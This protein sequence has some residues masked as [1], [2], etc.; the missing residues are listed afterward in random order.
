MENTKKTA[1]T[2]LMDE[3]VEKGYGFATLK[4]ALTDITIRTSMV[5]V[6]SDQLIF[7]LPIG[8]VNEDGKLPVAMTSAN[9]TR[10]VSLDKKF[11]ID[12]GL[13]EGEWEEAAKRG[14]L[15]R[16]INSRSPILY[17]MSA[18][19]PSDF[20]QQYDLL[21]PVLKTRKSALQRNQYIM[22]LASEMPKKLSLVL[23]K[24]SGNVNKALTLRSQRYA[25]I[26][27]TVILDIIKSVEK[28]IGNSEVHNWSMTHALTQVDIEFPAMSQEISDTYAVDGYQAYVRVT[29]SDSGEASLRAC[30]MLKKNGHILYC[31]D[32]VSRKHS[33]IPD[34]IR[35]TKDVHEQIFD[36]FI[37]LPEYLC[38]MAMMDV[39]EPEIFVRDAFVDTEK[40]VGKGL[41]RR[42]ADVVVEELPLGETNMLT[43]F[44][45]MMAMPE[46]VETVESSK[47]KLRTWLSKLP[48]KLVAPEET[49]TIL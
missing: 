38:E 21:G 9:G 39:D 47:Q 14:F 3:W 46:R 22:S 2:L 25:H 1:P 6:D 43:I 34:I 41:A 40:V 42:V 35:F 26:P 48:Y 49:I 5:T 32:D 8:E 28:D 12:N 45:M 31:G 24:G 4:E 33:G 15:A 18:D 23:R 16:R 20:A 27:Q 36:K 29:D 10:K 7:I 37:M 30:G 11:L 17:P 44:E 13:T 19:I